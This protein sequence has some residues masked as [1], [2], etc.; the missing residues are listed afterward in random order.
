[1]TALQYRMPSG[2][3]LSAVRSVQV[4]FE[5]MS[6]PE[7]VEALRGL[8]YQLGHQSDA[9]A[10]LAQALSHPRQTAGRLAL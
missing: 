9:A 2:P 6:H 4:D 5:E 7:L 10:A 3:P 1:M 8:L